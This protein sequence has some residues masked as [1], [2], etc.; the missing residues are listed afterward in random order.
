MAYYNKNQGSG[1][2]PQ[3]GAG[4][5]SF[6]NNNQNGVKETASVV[7]KKLE[8]KSSWITKE[9]TEELVKYA[10]EAGRFMARNG[11]TNSKIRSIYG[12]I[13]RIQMGVFEKEKSSFYLLRPK[14]AYALGRD[15]KNEGLKL[16]KMIFDQ[17]AVDVSDQKS[18]KNF[19]GFIEAILAYH[20]AYGGK[21]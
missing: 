7:F 5:A 19:C 11:L 9:A 15:D 2:R 20:K 18:Y 4:G 6:K 10:E 8:Y 14:V 13:K 1:F 21:D 16:F 12:E 3:T 17:C